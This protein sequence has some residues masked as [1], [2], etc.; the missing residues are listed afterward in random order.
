MFQLSLSQ[1]GD[2]DRMTLLLLSISR[3]S[4]A[5]IG[6]IPCM[7][8]TPDGNGRFVLSTRSEI[9][10]FLRSEESDGFGY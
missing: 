4:V 9:S 3:G 8:L 5:I 10:R 6:D 1:D 7:G 2:Q